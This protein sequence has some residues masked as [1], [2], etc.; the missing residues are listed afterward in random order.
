[1]ASP[2]DITGLL[3]QLP[4][5][6]HRHVALRLLAVTG[7][8]P[9]QLLA[10]LIA[11]GS[12]S[13]ELG[14]YLLGAERQ[15][16][17]G[18]DAPLRSLLGDPSVASVDLLEIRGQLVAT[19]LSN[20]GGASDLAAAARMRAL[21]GEAS[22]AVDLLEL[23]AS[24]CTDAATKLRLRME[25]AYLRNHSSVSDSSS[26]WQ[27]IIQD[28]EQGNLVGG[29]RDLARAYLFAAWPALNDGAAE[30]L[31]QGAQLHQAGGW[32]DRCRALLHTLE[33]DP[34]AAL[35]ADRSA[36]TD[37]RLHSDVELEVLALRSLASNGSEVGAPHVMRQI[38]DAANLAEANDLHCWA[39]ESMFT[40]ADLLHAAGDLPMAL[41]LGRQML[42][43]VERRGLGPW[44]CIVSCAVADQLLLAGSITEAH[45]L[46]FSRSLDA[47]REV[48]APDLGLLSRLRAEAALLRGAPSAEVE[49]LLAEAEAEGSASFAE[50]HFELL[51]IRL[52]LS[53]RD[54]GIG[55]ALDHLNEIPF[56]SDSQ[57]VRVALFLSRHA[58]WEGNSDAQQAAI[59]LIE[60]V[61]ATQ[62]DP[63]GALC[64]AELVLLQVS[65]PDPSELE[66]MA[67][68][69][70]HAGRALEALRCQLSAVLAQRGSQGEG[71]RAR[72]LV[73]LS[74][75]LRERGAQLD[76]LLIDAMASGA[77]DR[78]RTLLDTALRTSDL[79]A[80]LDG[81]A[82]S[83]VIRHGIIQQYP[84]EHQFHRQGDD[85]EGLHI[86]LDG[87]ARLY[88]IHP[89]GRELTLDVLGPGDALGDLT[90]GGTSQAAAAA[91]ATESL[92]VLTLPSATLRELEQRHPALVARMATC[93]SA[94]RQRI[95]DM[96]LDFA[97]SSAQQRFARLLLNLNARFGHPTLSGARIINRRMTQG[98]IATMI[99]TSRKSVAVMMSQLKRDGIVDVDRKRL[100]LH[101]IERIES[102]AHGDD[103][104]Q[105]AA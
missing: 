69:W 67:R 84:G 2:T 100:V 5:G 88:R 30:L 101:S 77:S 20:N 87:G 43:Y 52:Q 58:R 4:L 78:M 21:A 75:Q 27:S 97:Y 104:G 68:R 105:M 91:E 16:S 23:A 36:L 89:D 41:Q 63:W 99:G 12:V 93:A 51:N 15:P 61:D 56:S 53:A 22:R 102:M 60:A 50:Y 54:A 103:Q 6:A 62:L 24:H 19:G 98:E 39:V 9:E 11:N 85:V 90:P 10:E 81:S 14:D 86:I 65:E 82:R 79:L 38:Q 48:S 8:D 71:E 31:T 74:S 32:A 47:A 70:S 95:E 7:G 35:A 66:R 96:A 49:R 40:K 44:T 76:S 45:E 25:A 64:H 34:H 92:H 18:W 26:A 73:G 42:G 33:G 37:A 17:S 55:R 3:A 46:L 72:R 13:E 59:A 94:Q 57:R 1:M 83:D 29:E 28:I 80:G